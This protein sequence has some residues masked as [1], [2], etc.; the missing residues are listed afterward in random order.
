MFRV[1]SRIPVTRTVMRAE[2]RFLSSTAAS[3]PSS[4]SSSSA[5]AVNTTAL[6]QDYQK[7]IKDILDEYEE[8]RKRRQAKI[9]TIVSAKNA[10]TVSVEIQYEKYFPKYQTSLRRTRKIMAHDEEEKGQVGDIVRIV[11]CR[12]MSAR[13]RHSLMD[14]I[15][16]PKQAD[17][18]DA[19][20]A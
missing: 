2:A 4:S 16:R 10:K 13:K 8:R 1:I 3:T 7:E 18:V 17:A 15:R 12:P 20:E 9:G 5:T 11:P 19:V 6:E 14:I